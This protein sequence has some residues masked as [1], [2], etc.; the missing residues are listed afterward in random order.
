MKVG[1]LILSGCAALEALPENLNVS[2]LDIS[3][4]VSLQRWPQRGNVQVGRLNARGC[5]QLTNLPDWITDIAQLDVS[6]CVN[7]TDLPMDLR[8][9]SWID[10]ADTGIC[11]LPRGV[12]N[13]QVRWRGVA[14]DRRIALHPETITTQEILGTRNVELRRVLLERM[15]YETFMEQSQALLLDNDSDPGGPRCLLRVP[16]PNDEPL[17]CLSVRCPS[18]GRGYMLRVPPQLHTCRQAAAWLA[19]FDDADAYHPIQ[20]T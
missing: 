4:C 18:T 16:I 17:V 1:S 2:F 8:V 20:E 5:I 7:L 19:G 6:G 11:S 12:E 15:G 13:A 14:I 9:H 10:I 3:G